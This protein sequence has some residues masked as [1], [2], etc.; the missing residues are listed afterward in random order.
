ME[1]DQLLIRDYV[2]AVIKLGSSRSGVFRYKTKIHKTSLGTRPRYTRL[3]SSWRRSSKSS[4][5]YVAILFPTTLG[6]GATKLS[7]RC[8]IRC[9]LVF[10]KSGWRG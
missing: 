8:N 10:W 7:L 1:P 3:C 2:L 6:R 5:G 4:A 9:A